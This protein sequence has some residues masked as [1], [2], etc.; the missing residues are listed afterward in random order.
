MVHVDFEIQNIPSK[1]KYKY[2]I[3]IT[4]RPWASLTVCQWRHTITIWRPWDILRMSGFGQYDVRIWHRI[5]RILWTLFSVPWMSGSDV[6]LDVTGTFQGRQIWHNILLND[7]TRTPS[8][9]QPTMSMLDQNPTFLRHLW[10]PQDVLG[11]SESHLLVGIWSDHLCSESDTYMTLPTSTG[12]PGDIRTLVCH[13]QSVN[14][15]SHSLVKIWPRFTPTKIWRPG[16]SQGRHLVASDS[17]VLETP[18]WN[19]RFKH[20]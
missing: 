10:S 14:S 4:H 8:S 11:T 20:P 1:Y 16:P 5:Y 6:S 13:L 12:R 2:K 7:V 18:V 3:W 15:N 19:V 9:R 17:G